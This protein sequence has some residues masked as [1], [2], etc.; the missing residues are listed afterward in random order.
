MSR[1]VWRKPGILIGLFAGAS[2]LA[3]VACGSPEPTA[4]PVP[5]TATAT[6]TPRPATPTPTTAPGTTATVVAQPTAAA[7]ATPTPV[8]SVQPKRGGIVKQSGTEDPPTFDAHNA[9]SSAHNVHN[10]KLYSNLLWNPKGDEIVPDAAESYEVSADGKTWTFKLRPNVKFQ[11]GYTPSNPRDG[12][13]VTAQ[14]VKYSLMKI[15]GL[16]DGVLSARS[17]W[18]KEFIDIDRPDTG[19]EVVDSLTLKVHLTQPFAGLSNILA[20]GFSSIFPDGITSQQLARRPY[21]TG[22]FKV[23]LQNSQRG[24]LWIYPRN[25]DY[26]KTGLPY[27]DGYRQVN[28]DG[29]AIIQTAFLTGKIDVSAGNPTLDNKT[30]FEQRVKSGQVYMLPYSTG[31]RP[32]VINMNSTKPPFNDRKLREAI[33]LAPDRVAYSKVVHDGWTVPTLYLDTPGIG[34]TEAEIMQMPGWRQPHDADLAAAKKIVSELYPKGLDVSMIVRNSSNYQT[35]GEFLAGELKKIGINVTIQILDSTV[36]FDRAAKLDYS[37]WSYYFCQTTGTP[38]ELFGSYFITGGS[39]N[40]IGYSDPKIDAGYRDLA[41]TADPVVRK[42][43]SQDMEKT[44][45][46]F[47]P[48][49]PLPVHTSNRLVYSYVKDVPL[50]ITFYMWDK[51]ELIWRSDV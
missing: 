14:D 13:A 4:T 47:L 37:L 46:D 32:Q 30:I 9:T 48:S 38:E 34:H 7:T 28:M 20:I 29:T 5:P 19:L 31:C 12:T 24:A 6:S 17:G 25:P 1:S 18:M 45:L 49:A 8:P 3:A 40:W 39:R 35:Q 41:A 36:V 21:G 27:L 51:A 44:I 42:Q 22:P 11:T 16:T 15:M 43:K 2:L 26:F 50:T 10:A 33:N 23:D